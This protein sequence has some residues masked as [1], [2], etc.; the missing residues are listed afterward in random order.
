M[1]SQFLP[2]HQTIQHIVFTKWLYNW[3]EWVGIESFFPAH[4]GLLASWL[5][6]KLEDCPKLVCIDDFAGRRVIQRHI[7]TDEAGPGFRFVS[8]T[9]GCRTLWHA[10]KNAACLQLGTIARPP[11]V[12]EDRHDSPYDSEEEDSEEKLVKWVLPRRLCAPAHE[13]SSVD[14]GPPKHLDLTYY[15]GFHLPFDLLER[16]YEQTDMRKDWMHGQR[17]CELPEH[18]WEMLD[19]WAELKGLAGAQ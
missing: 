2:R 11:G 17:D 4:T 7:R 6:D 13:S 10:R 16:V 19:E 5:I 3:E 9:D 12:V 18:V 15:R 14:P 1:N 8:F